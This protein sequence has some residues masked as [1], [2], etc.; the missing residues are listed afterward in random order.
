MRIATLRS[1]SPPLLRAAQ[2]NVMP[3]NMFGR[4]IMVWYLTTVMKSSAMMSKM[5]RLSSLSMPTIP[6]SQ[7]LRM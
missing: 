3:I 2:M 7:H 6:L 4:S 5:S 1:P